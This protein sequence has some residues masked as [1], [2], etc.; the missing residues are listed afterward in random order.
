MGGIINKKE[1]SH[2]PLGKITQF[3][4]DYNPE[5]LYPISRHEK[6]QEIG[7]VEDL[8]FNG[9]D[10]WNSYEISWLDNKGKPHVAL[11]QFLFNSSS[12]FIVESKSLKLYLNSLN[13]HK[14]SHMKDIEATIKQDL[15][16]TTKSDVNVSLREIKDFGTINL[17]STIGQCIDNLDVEIIEYEYSPSILQSDNSQIVN[18]NLC[19][20]LLKSNC[21]VTNQPDWGTINIKYT[22]PKI[23]HE[24]LLRYIVSYRTHNEFHEQCV[25]RI[26]MDIMK[27]C[28]PVILT[29]LANYT[30]RGG[31]DIN[32]YRTTEKE[33]PSFIRTIRQ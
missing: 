1:L 5:I 30:R 29:V 28:Q 9:V 11:G 25:E 18:E 23:N 21:L 31:L 15:S 22:G 20:H 27:S 32:P 19:S 13:Q 14:F 8:P 4:Q 16:D 10:V 12:E 7:I 3:Q 26:F 2:S 24:S 17:F 33:I 6:R